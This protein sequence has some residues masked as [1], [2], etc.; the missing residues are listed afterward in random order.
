MSES[1]T[2]TPQQT[3]DKMSWKPGEVEWTKTPPARPKK[4][5]AQRL[6]DRIRRDGGQQ[7]G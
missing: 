1:Q 6:A 4:T 5:A 3:Q 2:P 7:R